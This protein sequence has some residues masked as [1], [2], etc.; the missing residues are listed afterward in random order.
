MTFWL[1]LAFGGAAG[2]LAR[3]GLASWVYGRTGA[4]FPWGTL[5]VNVLGAFLLG[6]VMTGLAGSPLQIQLGALLA[7]GFLGDFTTFSTLSYEAVMLARERE[8]GR[9]LWYLLGTT[10]LGAIAIVLGMSLGS[11]LS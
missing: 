3:Y 10:A 9:A 5:V 11:R 7:T 4:E 6:V 8:Y 1:L 2:A